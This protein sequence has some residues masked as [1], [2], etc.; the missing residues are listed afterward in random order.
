T[1][2]SPVPLPLGGG[3]GARRAGEG[4]RGSMRQDL[5][6][7][8]LSLRKT[9]MKKFILPGIALAA[10]T[11][12]LISVVR[13]QPQRHPTTPPS[14]PPVSTYAHTVAAVGLVETSTENIAVGT[15]LADVVAEVLVTVGQAVKKGDPL[16]RLDDRQLR[17]DLGAR[18]A[19][20]RVAESQVKVNAAVLDD[21][22]RQLNFAENLRDKS[23]ISSE[24]LARRRSAVETAQARLDEAK[25]QVASAA[26]QIKMIET[27]IERSTV[28]ASVDG[29]VLQVKVH[30]GEFAPAGVTT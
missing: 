20:R 5:I 27:Q 6:K 4:F 29:E 21:V 11:F 7:R 19:E 10:L 15:P 18:Q 12:G 23:A 2:P 28:R 14:P 3:E 25:A 1:T 22:T 24:E 13:S 16:F 9:T 17:A 8:N 30:P 26:A